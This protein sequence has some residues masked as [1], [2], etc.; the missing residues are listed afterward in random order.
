[1]SSPETLAPAPAANLHT[2]AAVVDTSTAYDFWTYAA[3]KAPDH[4]EAYYLKGTI[5][6]LAFYFFVH[7]LIHVICIRCNKVY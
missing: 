2:K 3:M 7:L 5:A 1:M 6:F 4:N